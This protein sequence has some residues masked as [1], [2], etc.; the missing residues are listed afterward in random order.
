M[1]IKE[2]KPFLNLY[3]RI[4]LGEEIRFLIVKKMYSVLVVVAAVFRV[5]SLTEC[6]KENGCTANHGYLSVKID[7]ADAV[8][9]RRSEFIKQICRSKILENL[10]WELYGYWQLTY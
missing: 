6:T 1:I 9:P 4:T 3:S 7:E 8:R 10:Y 2:K 5:S